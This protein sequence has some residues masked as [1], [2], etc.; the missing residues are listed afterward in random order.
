M[1]AD[2]HDNRFDPASGIYESEAGRLARNLQSL[3][4]IDLDDRANWDLRLTDKEQAVAKDALAA[5]SGRPLFVINVGGKQ[6]V[7]HW[8]EARW[9]ELIACLARQLADHSLVTVGTLQDFAPSQALLDSWPTATA[10]LCGLL[11]PRE[12][13]AIISHARFFVG[14]DSGPLHLAEAVNTP[15]IGL[16]GNNNLPGIWH[17][18]GDHHRPLQDLRGVEFIPVER[19]VS[20]V[21]DIAGRSR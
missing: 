20:T 17:P 4:D 13:A 3:A 9:M 10:N 15:T 1:A 12:S 6:A 8:G 18:H 5:V 14:H 7:N 16:F 19:V 2:L 21:L 11:S